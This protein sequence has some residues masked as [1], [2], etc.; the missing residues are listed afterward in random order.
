MNTVHRE[1][2]INFLLKVGHSLSKY[3]EH[4]ETCRKIPVVVEYLRLHDVKFDDYGATKR[5]KFSN[6]DNAEL[7]IWIL[8]KIIKR[9]Y[10]YINGGDSTF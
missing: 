1:E 5:K 8:I 7:L 2:V 10:D 3:P 9:I 6:R 4:A